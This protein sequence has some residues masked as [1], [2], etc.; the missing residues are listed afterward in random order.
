MADLKAVKIN[1][2]SLKTSVTKLKDKINNTLEDADLSEL[3]VYESKID[4]LQQETNNI[5]ETLFSLC[6]EK[7]ADEFINEKESVIETLDEIKIKVKR[8]LLN[9]N[10]DQKNSVINNSFKD[11]VVSDVKLP[12]LSLPIFNGNIEQWIEFQDLFTASVRNNNNLTNAQKL[13]YLKSACKADALNI[14]S[15][16]QISDAN[17]DIAWNLLVE[18]YSNKKDL[19][20]AIIKKLLSLSPTHETAPSLLKFVDNINECIRSLEVMEQ[21]IEG[22]SDTLIVHI[23]VEKLDKSTRVWYE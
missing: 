3:Q 8:K 11:A 7:D 18:R 15:S 1:K 2:K 17:Y 12:K 21:K 23:L 6:E 14:I 19:I 22:F 16:I 9:L 20:D 5:F 13:Q 10:Q 4:T